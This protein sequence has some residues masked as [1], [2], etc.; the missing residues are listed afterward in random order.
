[1]DSKI[2]ALDGKESQNFSFGFPFSFGNHWNWN[3]KAPFVVVA[4]ATDKEAV[5]S[6][7]FSHFPF[8]VVALA[9]FRL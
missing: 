8:V 6:S 9:T 5:C 2:L 7:G 3:P 4:L 1:M